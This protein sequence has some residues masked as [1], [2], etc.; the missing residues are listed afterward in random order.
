MLTEGH[1]VV[2]GPPP[3]SA[4]SASASVQPSLATSRTPRALRAPSASASAQ[5]AS[6]RIAKASRPRMCGCPESSRSATA[7][8]R[9]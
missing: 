5:P 1:E 2:V 6:C 4:A 8:S 9:W 7:E 3:A